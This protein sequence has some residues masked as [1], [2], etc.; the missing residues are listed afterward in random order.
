[1]ANV[2]TTLDD[3]R[4]NAGKVVPVD[5][6]LYWDAIGAVPPVG[7]KGCWAMGEE[8]GHSAQG[9]LWYWFAEVDE[10]E[11]FGFFGTR[12]AAETAFA[13]YREATA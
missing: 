7:G 6:E 2:V 9:V 5:S 1:M 4:A 10:G 13:A 12:E 8:A 3:L 11:F